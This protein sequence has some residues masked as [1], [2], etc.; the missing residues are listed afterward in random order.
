MEGIDILLIISLS[1]ISNAAPAWSI[2]SPKDYEECS[3]QAAKDAKNND[4]LRI[5]L[6]YCDTEFPARRKPE[7]GYHYY[8]GKMDRLPDQNYGYLDVSGPKLT[9][10]DWT[11]IKE[12]KNGYI[13]P[14]EEDEY[15]L[16]RLKNHP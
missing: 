9:K 7:G 4:S 14:E 16:W 10:S 2:F 13:R 15:N 8:I 3:V 12:K 1:L 11:K 6:D 5:L